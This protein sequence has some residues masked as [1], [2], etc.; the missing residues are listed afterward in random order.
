V[1]YLYIHIHTHIYIIEQLIAGCFSSHGHVEAIT[2]SRGIHL[3]GEPRSDFYGEL[4]FNYSYYMVRSIGFF[5][6]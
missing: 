6:A 1:I 4:F 2:G 5:Q 3:P